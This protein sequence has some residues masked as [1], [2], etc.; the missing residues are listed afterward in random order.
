MIDI[1]EQSRW[2]HTSGKEY[3]VLHIANTMATK[4]GY[5]SMVVY[6]DDDGNVWTRVVSDWHRSFSEAV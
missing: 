5:P 4:E 6:E 3:T 1:K 2:V